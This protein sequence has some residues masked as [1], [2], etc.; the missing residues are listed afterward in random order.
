[1]ELRSLQEKLPIA[2][3]NNFV[4]VSFREEMDTEK[5]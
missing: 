4:T 5:I 2:P 3:E 1:M